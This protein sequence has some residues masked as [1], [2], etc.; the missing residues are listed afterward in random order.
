MAWRVEATPPPAREFPVEL[1]EGL[2]WVKVQTPETKRDLNFILDTGANVSVLDLRIVRELG[3]RRGLTVSV[4]GVGGDVKGFWPQ[5]LEARAGGIE[6][7][8]SYLAVDLEKLGKACQR[9]VDGLLGADFFR[10]RAVRIDFEAMEAR[11]VEPAGNVTGDD[12]IAL[13]ARRCGFRVPVSVDGGPPQW[14]RLDTGCAA[15][16]HWVTGKVDP[17]HCAPR[18]A[19]A[20]TE[21]TTAMTETRVTLG[22]ASFPAVTTA[23]HE[24]E[25]FPGEA[26]LLGNGVLTQFASITI[27]AKAGRLILRKRG[28]QPVRFP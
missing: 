10:S 24:R 1:H 22:S 6:L 12:V 13:D 19:V 8:R 28:A 3:L 9:P 21:L 11:V 23:L 27:D 7:P 20:L 18:A 15:G 17:R 25:I 2:L 4:S 5:R 26:G 14:V 16:L